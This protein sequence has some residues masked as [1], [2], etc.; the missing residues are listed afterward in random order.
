M[1]WDELGREADDANQRDRDRLIGVYIAVLAVILAICAMGGGNA[2]KEAT[3]KNIEATNTWGFFQAKNMRRHVLRVQTDELE[4]LK[5]T[6]PALPDAARAAI[7]AKI[8]AYRAQD[9]ELTTEPATGEGLDELF[10]RGKALEA[11]RDRA[12]RK[13]PYFDYGEALLQ[14]AIV[15]G[16]VAIISGGSAVLVASFIMAALGTLMTL[17]GFTLLVPLPFLG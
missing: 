12:M 3:L 13:D 2:A 6:T 7:D 5:A 15:L 8:A 16:G 10:V 11:E 14:I 17:N 1:V 4:L 9:K